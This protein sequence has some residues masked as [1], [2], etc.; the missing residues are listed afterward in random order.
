[1]VM[2]QEWIKAK[3]INRQTLADNVME[4]TIETYQE[5]KVLPWQWA[6]FLF[7]D[8]QGTF[9]RWYSIVDHDTDNEK[10]MLI[11]AIKLLDQWRWSAI[12]KKTVI[13]SEITIKWIFGHFILQDTPSPKVFIWT[14]VGIAPVLNMAKYCLAEKRLFFSVSHKKDLFYE[15][16]IKKIHWLWHEIHISK[17]SLPGYSSWRIDLMK[18]NFSFDTEFYICWRPEVVQ[19][20]VEKLTFMWFKKIYFEKF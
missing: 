8:E 6:L 5:V 17:E 2:D 20:M 10:T 15:E 3:I 12:L 1:M 18:H 4:F 7:E 13:W 16:R 14:G 9:Q 19:D 11:F